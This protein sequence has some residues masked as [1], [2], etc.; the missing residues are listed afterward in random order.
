EHLSDAVRSDSA[1]GFLHRR[2]L[3]EALKERLAT[4]AAGG[5][6]ALAIIK[7]DK[8]GTIERDLGALASEDVLIEFAKL[9]KEA[10]HP[11]EIVGRFGGVKFL[12]LLERGN[13][14]DVEAWGQQLLG[15]VQKHAFRVKD[16]TVTVTCTVGF[17]VVPAGDIKLDASVADALDACV[18]GRGR[19]GNQSVTSDKA[20]TD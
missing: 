17:S 10:L 1:T 5:M 3:L 13:E 6:R 15:R 19:G 14:N 8:F 18:K 9:L 11:K 4:P 12:V 2:E 20:D 7:P 16:K